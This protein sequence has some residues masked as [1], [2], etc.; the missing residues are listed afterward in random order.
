MQFLAIVRRRTERF[1][2]AEFAPHLETEAEAVRAMHIEGTI[3]SIWSRGDCLGA[4]M[5][6]EAP[7]QE[8]AQAV[9]ERFPL[10]QLGMLEVEMLVP[11]RGYRGFAPRGSQQPSP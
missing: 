5:L 8:G 3:R 4:V 11:L 10:A 9:F 2:D 7:S 1:S 6:L